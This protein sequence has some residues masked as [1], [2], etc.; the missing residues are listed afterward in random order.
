MALLGMILVHFSLVMAADSTRPTWLA[1]VN[2][3]L[4]GRAAATFV[5]LAG[6]GLSLL[7]RR[8]VA[9]GNSESIRNVSRLFVYRGL[10]L[11]VLG[12]INLAIWPGDILRVYGVSLLLASALLT[13]SNRSLLFAALGF[14]IGFLVLFVVVDF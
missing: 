2:G 9:S 14:A 12:F 13:A 5:V 1:S 7:S 10:F 8:A 3:F 11:L 6:I 4:D